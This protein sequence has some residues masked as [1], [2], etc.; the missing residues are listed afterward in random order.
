MATATAASA[1]QEFAG[2][3]VCLC[4]D[5]GTGKS[6]IARAMAGKEFNPYPMMTI[7]FEFTTITRQTHSGQRVKLQVNDLAGMDRFRA[8]APSVFRNCHAIA[9]VYDLTCRQSFDHVIYWIKQALEVKS[10]F[11]PYI[12]VLGNKLDLADEERSVS[13]EEVRELCE[14]YNYCFLEMSAKC[15][16]NVDTFLDV[17]C[18]ELLAAHQHQ[19][20][21]SK[22]SGIRMPQPLNLAAVETTTIR[23]TDP[24]GDLP[25]AVPTPRQPL[26]S[27]NRWIHKSFSSV[28]RGRT[29]PT[30][31]PSSPLARSNIFANTI[32]I[33]DRPYGDTTTSATR[34]GNSS[35]S[36]CN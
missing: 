22:G 36:C 7:G 4:G 10:Q 14:R 31:A 18:E 6:A 28:G 5:A 17:M 9:A 27:P 35:S 23:I 2:F 16:I 1:S 19:L 30:T 20:G 24:G 11:D 21:P 26:E 13:T 34:R 25:N 3:K 8:I 15:A 32:N 29:V 12:F 33:A